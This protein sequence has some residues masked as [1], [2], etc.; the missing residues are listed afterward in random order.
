VG[1]EPSWL[2][3]R[4]ACLPDVRHTAAAKKGRNLEAMIKVMILMFM[5]ERFVIFK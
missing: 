4:S 2:L 3:V 5:F 1:G